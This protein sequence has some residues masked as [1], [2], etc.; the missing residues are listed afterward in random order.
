MSSPN[1]VPPL[2]SVTSAERCSEEIKRLL[3]SVLKRIIVS[4][5]NDLINCSYLQIY[6]SQYSIN[7]FG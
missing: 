7:Q 2:K 6:K 4:T 1:D 3:L 5:E